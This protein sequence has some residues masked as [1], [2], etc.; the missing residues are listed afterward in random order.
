MKALRSLRKFCPVERTRIPLRYIRATI[1]AQ[2]H[3]T[4][5][6][7]RFVPSW[8]IFFFR[9]GHEIPCPIV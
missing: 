9:F 4:K 2:A 5:T 3:P 7:V 6:F 8:S 1:G